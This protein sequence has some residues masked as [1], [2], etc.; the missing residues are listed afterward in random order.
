MAGWLAVCPRIELPEHKASA[1]A[2]NKARFV[3]NAYPTIFRRF[4][5]TIV[6]QSDSDA[7]YCT[8]YF[9]DKTWNSV[10]L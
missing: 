5:Q 7:I 3:I 1:S 9:N 4:K 6:V 10:N 2:N 8:L